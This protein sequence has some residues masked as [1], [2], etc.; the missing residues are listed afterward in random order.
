MQAKAPQVHIQRRE[1]V[2]LQVLIEGLLQSWLLDPQAYDLVQ[3]ARI[4][5]GTYLRGLG[6]EVWPSN[7]KV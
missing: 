7:N 2:G 5:V 6:L 4:S 1:A 3:A